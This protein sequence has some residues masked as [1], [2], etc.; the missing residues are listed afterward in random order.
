MGRELNVEVVGSRVMHNYQLCS[1]LSECTYR[2]L[3]S[4]STYSILISSN[5]LNLWRTKPSSVEISWGR[6]NKTE[7]K[8]EESFSRECTSVDALRVS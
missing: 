3:Y 6:T 4:L 2:A 7:A 8:Q 1:K 5:F